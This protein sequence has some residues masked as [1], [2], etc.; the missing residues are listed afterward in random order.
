MGETTPETTAQLVS[1]ILDCVA[2][3]EQRFDRRAIGGIFVAQIR[4]YAEAMIDQIDQE[5]RE[6]AA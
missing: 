4:W 2:A 1:Q 5:R 6:E 3:L